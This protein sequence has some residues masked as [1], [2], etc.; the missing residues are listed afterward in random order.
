MSRLKGIAMADYQSNRP[1]CA[2]SRDAQLDLLK[3]L[4]PDGITKEAER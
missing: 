1:T 4:G 3:S 2:T